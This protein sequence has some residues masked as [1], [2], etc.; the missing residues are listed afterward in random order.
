MLLDFVKVF[1]RWIKE[2]KKSHTGYHQN[3]SHILL[4]GLPIIGQFIHQTVWNAP[5]VLPAV[6]FS[7]YAATEEKENPFIL[8]G[9][10]YRFER[11]ILFCTRLIFDITWS[12]QYSTTGP[13]RFYYHWYNSILSG[14]GFFRHWQDQK[15]IVAF[16]WL[17]VER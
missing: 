15:P 17:T 11:I 2:R 4:F 6:G 10:D 14:Y 3:Y 9:K 13:F 5:N 12:M 7:N 16:C 1:N 8:K